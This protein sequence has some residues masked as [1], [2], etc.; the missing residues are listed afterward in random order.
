[1]KVAKVKHICVTLSNSTLVEHFADPPITSIN[2]K[3]AM[4][5]TTF[6]V[7]KFFLCIEFFKVNMLFVE[8]PCAWKKMYTRS[9]HARKGH[10]TTLTTSIILVI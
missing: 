10:N 4:L 3:G 6:Y 5:I 7:W 2:V 8:F 9:Y 1:M